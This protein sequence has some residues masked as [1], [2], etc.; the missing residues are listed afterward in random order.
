MRFLLL[1]DIHGRIGTL[2]LILA[3]VSRNAEP[4]AAV[5]IAGDLTSFGAAKDAAA[6]IAAVQSHFPELP[7]AAVAGNCDPPEVVSWLEEAGISLESRLRQVGGILIAG[8]GGGLCHNGTTPFER[9]ESAFGKAFKK[10]FREFG[11]RGVS[12]LPLVGLTHSPPYGADADIRHHRHIGS[13]DI[14]EQLVDRNALAWVCGHIHEARSVSELVSTIV[15]N[16]GPAA[17]GCHALLDIARDARGG[18][19]AQAKLFSL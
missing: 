8:A 7:I 15:V 6:V 19:R 14:F 11:E 9:S 1:S 13:K 5:L 4:L 10:A 3:S 12:D 18:W 16:P 17:E 2:E